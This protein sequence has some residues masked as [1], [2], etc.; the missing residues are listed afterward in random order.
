ML[1]TTRSAENLSSSMVEDA[2]VG[3]IGG[4]CEDETV[5]RSSFTS[6]NS[7]RATG[8]LTPGTKQAFTQLRQAFTK[9]PIFRHFDSE[10]HIRIE[11][12]VSGYAIGGSLSQLTLDNLSQW[13]PVA[14]SSQKMIPAETWYKT[15]NGEL[16]AIVKAFKT[17]R[18]YVKDCKH[19]VLVLIDHNNLRRFMD[20]RSLS[21]RQV[22]WAQE[23]SKYY[24]WIDYYQSK[25][26]GAADAL[27]RFPQK[28]K[29]EEKKLWTE[30][31]QI[32]HCLQSL[33]T[34]ATLSGLSTSLSLLSLHQVFICRTHALPQLRQFWNTFELKLANEGPYQASINSMRLRLQEL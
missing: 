2:E 4:D 25:A 17:W 7:N 19:K 5:K 22:R 18:H 26:N 29:D 32:F 31:T 21:S 30:N 13:H 16:L 11:T 20:I 1:R 14:F 3:S 9:A 12:D 6:K 27:F 24:F 34:S 23:L 10:C 15:H 28:N 8:Y 33:L